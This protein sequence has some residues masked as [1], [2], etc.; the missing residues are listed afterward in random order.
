M[1]LI[2]TRTPHRSTD[3]PENLVAQADALASLLDR[4]GRDEPVKVT[5]TVGR[6]LPQA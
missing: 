4:I 3:K 5:S 1:Q 2:T 6:A